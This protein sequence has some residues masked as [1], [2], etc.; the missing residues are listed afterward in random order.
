MSF[1][2][3]F[4]VPDNKLLQVLKALQLQGQQLLSFN[5]LH[6][7]DEVKQQKKPRA[8]AQPESQAQAQ[9]P[10]KKRRYKSRRKNKPNASSQ[11]DTVRGL[12]AQIGSGAFPILPVR[13]KAKELGIDTSVLYQVIT[14]EINSGRLTRKGPGLYQRTGASF[15]EALGF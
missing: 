14:E 15:K 8:H 5:I 9:P 3:A 13:Q 11:R 10:A 4:N 1:T 2:V 7:E 12:F 6:I